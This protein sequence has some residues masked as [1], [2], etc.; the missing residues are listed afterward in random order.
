MR[1]SDVEIKDGASG[2]ERTG[3]SNP[4]TALT[5]R[6]LLAASFFNASSWKERSTQ[7][8]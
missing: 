1:G 6:Q 5:G 3:L 2:L 4:S 8:W 7:R